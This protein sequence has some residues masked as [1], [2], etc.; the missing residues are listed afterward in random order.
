MPGLWRF[1]EGKDKYLVLRRDGTRPE[2]PSFVL[3]GK[4]VAAPEALRAYAQAATEHNFDPD[5]VEDIYRLA[6][7]F[8]AYREA[9]GLG[10]PDGPRH[11]QDDPVTIAMM[12]KGGR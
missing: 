4:D 6:D 12:P 7:E 10:D 11:R 8:D 1:R 2:W 9:H 3:G 5:Y